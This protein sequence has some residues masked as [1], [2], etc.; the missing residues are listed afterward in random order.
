M[1]E[2]CF[3]VD[4]GKATLHVASH[5]SNK[6]MV[7][8]HDAVGLRQLVQHLQGAA[9]VVLEATGGWER[10]ALRALQ[11]AEIAVACI[12]PKQA[13][14]FA[15]ATGKLAKTDG[16]DACMLAQFAER[17]RPEVR[18]ALSAVQMALKDQMARRTQLVG[19]RA[20]EKNRRAQARGDW[21]RSIEAHIRFLDKEIARFEKDMAATL[22]RDEALWARAKLLQSVPGV[23]PVTAMTLAACLPELGQLSHK[24]LAALVGVA[25]FNRDSGARSGPRSIRGGRAAVRRVMY[26]AALSAARCHP[27]M[28]AFYQRLIDAG[29]PVKVALTA[30]IRKLLTWLNA[31]VRDGVVRLP[32]LH[33]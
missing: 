27:P 26:M 10:P 3:G 13:R 22:R 25:P 16:V 24:Q 9:L 18:P 15:K 1:S 12:N 19:I 8:A 28:R 23:G 14:D 4:V 33:D 2:I 11:Q 30:C 29:K 31:I 5:R 6:V 21:K 17:L 20:A 7:F 32:Q